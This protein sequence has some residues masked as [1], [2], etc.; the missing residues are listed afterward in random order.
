MPPN[1]H[2]SVQ[3]FLV[4]SY[5]G[6]AYRGNI[7]KMFVINSA[8]SSILGKEKWSMVS[9]KE[10]RREYIRADVPRTRS[11]LFFDL[12]MSLVGM[13]KYHSLLGMR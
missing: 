2:S 9:S 12:Y 4:S 11:R 7:G 5:V 8:V 13:S 1:L 3:I 10:E 6:W